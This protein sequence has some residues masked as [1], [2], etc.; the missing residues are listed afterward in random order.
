MALKP[1]KI[2]LS[3]ESP[4]QPAAMYSETG[5][6]LATRLRHHH[7][8]VIELAHEVSAAVSEIAL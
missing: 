4:K 3:S 8:Q 6:I 7:H 1:L 2:S 5:K